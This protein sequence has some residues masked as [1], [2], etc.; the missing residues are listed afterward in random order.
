MASHK[1][2]R[3]RAKSSVSRAY[4]SIPGKRECSSR[5]SALSVDFE[6]VHIVSRRRGLS[7]SAGSVTKASSSYDDVSSAR[8]SFPLKQN[9]WVLDPDDEG[10]VCYP[11]K[12]LQEDFQCF[13]TPTKPVSFREEAV[14]KP[15]ASSCDRAARSSSPQQPSHAYRLSHKCSKP[16]LT[17]S[18]SRPH[19]T[20][21]SKPAGNHKGK[22][23]RTSQTMPKTSAC[24]IKVGKSRKTPFSAD[25]ERV[26]G[27]GCERE[28][29]RDKDVFEEDSDVL[30][31]LDQEESGEEEEEA[32]S[33]FFSDSCSSGGLVGG[34]AEG[35]S[36]FLKKV[37][38]SDSSGVWSDASAQDHHSRGVCKWV[39]GVGV[40]ESVVGGREVMCWGCTMVY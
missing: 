18:A 27:D 7:S 22:H 13:S 14:L 34:V 11:S 25:E 19:T 1:G 2:G 16:P 21:V 23:S 6:Q 40:V 33:V 20:S 37:S 3:E 24:A 15:S 10:E 29:W 17:G 9:S 5:I 8:P 32:D 30:S 12:L 35:R 31:G 28:E 26:P 38:S 4:A 36:L 39:V